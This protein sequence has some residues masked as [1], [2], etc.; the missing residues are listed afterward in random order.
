M[1]KDSLLQTMGIARGGDR[2][3]AQ[4]AKADPRTPIELYNPKRYTLV[5]YLEA[6]TQDAWFEIWEFNPDRPMEVVFDAQGRPTG[7]RRE[8]DEWSLAYYDDDKIGHYEALQA[9]ES[10]IMALLK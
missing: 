5:Y 7:L 9:L 10:I 1:P 2:V 6:G 8:D 3:I 4:L